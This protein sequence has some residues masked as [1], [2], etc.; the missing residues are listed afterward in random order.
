MFSKLSHFKIG[1][2]AF[3]EGGGRPEGTV[4]HYTVQPGTRTEM[5]WCEPGRM[6]DAREAL[7]GNIVVVRYFVAQRL[8]ANAF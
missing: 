1:M 3:D 7:K 5:P 6:N 4:N 2:L 8:F